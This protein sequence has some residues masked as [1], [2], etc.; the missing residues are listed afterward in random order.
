MRWTRSTEGRATADSAVFYIPAMPATP[1]NAAYVR[2]QAEKFAAGRTPPDF[3]PNDSEVGFAGRGGVADLSALG[4]RMLGFERLVPSPPRCRP[5]TRSGTLRTSRASTG[6]SD[7]AET[8]TETEVGG[9]VTS[10]KCVT[11]V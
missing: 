2:R 1:A 3:P 7:L 11:N 9:G 4:R 5:R 10:V 8:E 6:R